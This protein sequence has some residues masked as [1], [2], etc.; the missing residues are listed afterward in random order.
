MVKTF[1]IR[2][3]SRFA[4]AP[5]GSHSVKRRAGLTIIEVLVVVAIL[6]V[7]LALFI[8]AVQAARQ[9]ARNVECRNNLRNLGLACLTFHDTR[10]YFPRNTIRPRGVTQIDGEPPG[11]LWE[12]SSGSFESWCRQ[13]MPL[14]EQPNA[15][16]QD[17]ILLLGCPS[18]PRG[19]NYK[20]PTYGFTWYVG[21]YSNPKTENNGVIVDDSDGNGKYTVSI[22]MVRDGTSNT[23]MLGERSPPADGQWGWWDTKCCIEDTISPVVGKRDRY[24]NGIFGSCPEPAYYRPADARDNCTFNSLSAYHAGGGN[25]C[26]ADGSV[27]TIAFHVVETKCGDKTLLEVLASRSGSEI[28]SEY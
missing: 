15:I 9:S 5:T 6:A 1:S 20:I 25:F 8:P 10:G 23:I 2:R 24:S 27:R 26:M 21:V 17:A 19:P 18:D 16:A 4:V 28:L 7:L 22:S 3:M 13:I 11:N 12:W 14:I